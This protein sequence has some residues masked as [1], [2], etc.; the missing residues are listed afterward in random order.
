VLRLVGEPVAFAS[1][2]AMM[3]AVAAQVG[4]SVVDPV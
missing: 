1:H 4:L 2:D 3:K